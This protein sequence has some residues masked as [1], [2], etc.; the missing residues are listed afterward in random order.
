MS[1]HSMRIL[2]VA[3]SIMLAGGAA[4]SAGHHHDGHETAKP[5]M[6]D[7]RKWPTDAPLRQGM[8]GIRSALQPRQQAVH[9]N[10]LAVAQYRAL[11]KTVN[12]Q[13]SLIVA[14]CKLP[15]EADVQLHLVVADLIAAAEAMAGQNKSLSRRDGALLL[16]QALQ[17]Y[18]DR[19]EHQNWQFAAE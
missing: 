7:G 17:A 13:V 10:R 1:L 2:V 19:F 9:D 18:G 11:A 14:S 3:T 16:A 6:N 4:F 8:D 5:V 15:P 12:A